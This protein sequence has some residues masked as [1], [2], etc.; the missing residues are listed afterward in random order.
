MWSISENTVSNR[1]Q[2]LS[3]TMNLRNLSPDSSATHLRNTTG[4]N[5]HPDSVTMSITGF[6]ISGMLNL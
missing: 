6:L 4:L 2:L 3:G 1:R 5:V